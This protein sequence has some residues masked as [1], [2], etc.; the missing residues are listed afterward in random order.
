MYDNY[1]NFRENIGENFRANLTNVYFYLSLL[2][3]AKTCKQIVKQRDHFYENILEW[4]ESLAEF[5]NNISFR[6]SFRKN[7]CKTGANER[8]DLHN[9]VSS[10]L[11]GWSVLAPLLLISPFYSLWWFN[12][13]K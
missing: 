1:K 11:A 6:K 13:C 10:S 12:K 7:M 8:E 4:H 2:Q 5:P 3:K 9:F